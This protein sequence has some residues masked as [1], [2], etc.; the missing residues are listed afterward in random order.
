MIQKL[1][2]T[3]ELRLFDD[4]LMLPSTEAIESLLSDVLI[5]L[6]NKVPSDGFL[7]MTVKK[8]EEGY[9][10][11]I[12]LASA[13]LRF[14]KKTTDQNLLSAIDLAVEEAKCVVRLWKQNRFFKEDCN[15]Y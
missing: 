7:T 5:D 2:E 10:V 1:T 4:G 9:R 12:R 14:L 6:S 8:G 13:S 15:E 11:G 3:F